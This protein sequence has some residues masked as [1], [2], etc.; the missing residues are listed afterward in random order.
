MKATTSQIDLNKPAELNILLAWQDQPCVSI[1]VPTRPGWSESPRN[2]LWYKNLLKEARQQL[3][4]RG[5]ERKDIQDL[6]EQAYQL[7]A[8]DTFWRSQGQGLALFLSKKNLFTYRSPVH[9]EKRVIVDDHFHVKPLLK[10]IGEKG[11]FYVLAI[12][13]GDVRLL[14]GTSS[15]LYDLDLK[16]APRSLEE[17]LKHHVFEKQHQFHGAAKQMQ[18]T[19]IG[20]TIYHGQGGATDRSNTKKH[21][22]EYF[23]QIDN[24]VCSMLATEHVPLVLAGLNHLTG[25]YRKV[26]HYK[27]ISNQKVDLNPKAL[28]LKELHSRI[29]PILEPQ[30]GQDKENAN[31]NSVTGLAP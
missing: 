31:S 1:Y 19:S 12:S 29:W 20:G 7:E 3:L 13:Q 30:F 26:N 22:K 14:K 9:F 5:L 18:N 6:L 8:N 16:G 17:A 15:S 28:S 23:K 11:H 4:E 10:L 24:S 25:I 21:V 2:R 27:H